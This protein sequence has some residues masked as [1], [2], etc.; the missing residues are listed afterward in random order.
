M[1]VDGLGVDRMDRMV[2]DHQTPSLASAWLIGSDGARFNWHMAVK[3]SSSLLPPFVSL[4]FGLLRL[5]LLCRL[6]AS[7]N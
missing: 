2:M 6:P 4:R 3:R 5:M 7:P 1:Q